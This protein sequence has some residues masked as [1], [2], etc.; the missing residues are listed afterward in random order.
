MWQPTKDF[1][2]RVRATPS[3]AFT[4]DAL[5]C[6]FALLPATILWG[7][8]FP[9]TLAAGRAARLHA[10][11]L[12]HQRHQH[13][14][15][16]GRRDH[17]HADRHSLR[18]AATAPQQALVLVAAITGLSLLV[19]GAPPNAEI[20]SLRTAV[21]V[22]ALAMAI[23]PAVPGRL[24]AYGRSVNSW[25]SIKRFL[26]LAE[27]ATASIAVTEGTSAATRQFHIAGKVEASDI[28][29]DMRLERML[30]HVPAL[31]HPQSKV[32]S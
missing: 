24:I 8:S 6:G 17:V 10:A 18:L 14:R 3:Y 31:I 12:A 26:Y 4:F 32:R 15:R 29:I 5:R 13:R 27:G 21:V 22:A 16:T 2:P 30:G 25:D 28:D 20:A 1:L 11:R 9:L 19:V 7:A 23:V